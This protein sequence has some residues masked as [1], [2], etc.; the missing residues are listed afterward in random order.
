MAGLQLVS[1]FEAAPVQ[2]T[3]SQQGQAS[4]LVTAPFQIATIEFSPS[5]EIASLVLNSSSK[6]VSVQLPGAGP[7]SEG[8][9]MFEIANLQLTGGG[10]IGMLQLNLLGHGPKRA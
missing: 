10:E 1:N 8:A 9:P 7:G 4:V 5:F 3:P 2:L 6:Q